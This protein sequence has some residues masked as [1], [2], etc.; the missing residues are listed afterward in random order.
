MNDEATREYGELLKVGDAP[1]YFGTAALAWV[2][3]QPSDARDPEVL[4]FAFRAMRNGCNL[5]KSTSLRHEVFDVLHKKYGDSEWAK[6][7][8]V[9]ESPEQ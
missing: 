7:Y 4:G 6:R 3:E 1:A 5:E 2:R 8:A 9:F